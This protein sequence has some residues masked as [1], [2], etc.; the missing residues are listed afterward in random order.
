MKPRLFFL[1]FFF[2]LSLA[3][4]VTRLFSLQVLSHEFYQ[5]LAE[6][7]H[8][9]Y[10]KLVPA[11]GEIFIK[12]DK[13]GRT[14]PVVTNIEKDLVY[15]VPPEVT[16]KER[17]AVAL[18][19]ILELSKKEILEKISD[20]GR[21]WVAIKKELPESTSVK[22]RNL[23]QPGIYLQPETHRYYPEKEFASQ[24]LGF[25]AYQEEERIGRYGIEEYFEDQLKGQAGSLVFE[26]DIKG[27]WIVGG[28]RKLEP[29]TDGADIV[30]TIDRAIQF[31]A[32]EILKNAVSVNQADAGSLVV[33]EPE[34]GKIL[35][36]ANQPSFDP[37]NFKKVEDPRIFR[38]L[39]VSDVYEPGSVFKP[40]T[41]ATGL[42]TEAVTPDLT[43][44]DLGSVA[45]DDFVI[46][47]ALN[48]VFG[49][50]TMT[51]VLEQSINTGAIFVQQKVGQEKFLEY[52]QKFGFGQVTGVNLA[53]E[54]AGNLD[55]LTKRG[56]AVHYATSAFGQGITVTLLQL[57][58]AFGAIA[59][60]GKLMKP[61]IV[62]E[63]RYAD[64]KVEKFNPRG[65]V[66]AISQRAAATLQAM[67]VSVV[68]KGHGKRAGIAGYYIGGKTGTAQVARADG[69][70]YDPDKTIGTF[71][72]FG[73]VENPAFVIAVRID[74]PKAVR[75]AESTAAPTFGEL[76]RFLVNYLQIP[77]TR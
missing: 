19:S 72:G 17:T 33:L 15:A 5:N 4:I 49:T 51:Q 44:E 23:K 74:N 46:R 38:N 67:L 7:Q 70:G 64:G 10:K 35:A 31:K 12:E 14:V 6:N 63:I 21:K 3:V 40:I 69:P 59:N 76:A 48:K 30:L 71:V 29:A 27:R 45:L 13:R 8:Q 22:I 58:Q 75:F 1:Q 62:D 43:Y 37:N 28:M 77:P 52:V 55:N 41:M 57:A 56:G 53:A 47:N 50:Q 36:I 34:T 39:V 68:E 9:L 60:Q 66:E 25:Y 11:R 61:Y 2:A 26:K 20:T 16:D 73:P 42:D 32:E 54:A 18:A 24:V 65:Q